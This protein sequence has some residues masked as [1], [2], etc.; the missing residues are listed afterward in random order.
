[1]LKL[2]TAYVVCNEFL[3]STNP[4][5][6]FDDGQCWSWLAARESKPSDQM[7]RCPAEVIH[8]IARRP[9]GENVG[10]NVRL[11]EQ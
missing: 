2:H 7:W 10:W 3:I 11:V 5:N 9:F 1:M 8:I 6:G 4:K